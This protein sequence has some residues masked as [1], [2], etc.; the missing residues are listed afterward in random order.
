MKKFIITAVSAALAIFAFMSCWVG[1][2]EY[3]ESKNY[4]GLGDEAGIV[5]TLFF[6]LLVGAFS[7]RGFQEFWTNVFNKDKK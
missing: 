1:C 4:F 6:A 2:M 3:L 7:F 5:F